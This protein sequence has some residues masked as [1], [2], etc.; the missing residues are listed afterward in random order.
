M[1]WWG[2]ERG[3][4]PRELSDERTVERGKPAPYVREEVGASV[5]DRVTQSPADDCL[6]E[7]KNQVVLIRKSV[8]N[9]KIWESPQRSLD[10]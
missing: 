5:E 8:F 7:V 9:V 3:H 1:R 2:M 10:V 4:E 6:L